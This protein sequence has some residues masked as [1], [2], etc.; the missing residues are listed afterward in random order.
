MLMQTFMGLIIKGGYRLPKLT[1]MCAAG[2]V[3]SSCQE[4][5]DSNPDESKGQL[6]S[7]RKDCP[8]W[9][10]SERHIDENICCGLAGLIQQGIRVTDSVFGSIYGGASGAWHIK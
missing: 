8:G 3:S 9:M 1:G 4:T 10:L 2:Q 7:L 6:A 5:A